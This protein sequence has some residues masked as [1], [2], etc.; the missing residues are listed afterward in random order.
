MMDTRIVLEV[1]HRGVITATACICHS[2]FGFWSRVP[3][4]WNEAI[5][6]DANDISDIA[7]YPLGRLY[8]YPNCPKPFPCDGVRRRISRT[9]LRAQLACEW[10]SVPKP[11]RVRPLCSFEKWQTYGTQN[12]TSQ[13]THN[14]KS[15]TF[16]QHLKITTLW[17]HHQAPPPQSLHPWA[18]PMSK[19][20]APSAWSTPFTHTLAI[21]YIL[22]SS[23]RT[24]SSFKLVKT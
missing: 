22:A 11:S 12:L 21:V 10:I 4:Y 5:K 6:L 9:P 19:S 23:K 17:F 13:K 15:T 20:T 14:K 3:E 7:F 18:L 8:S 2:G 1:C 24:E 16:P